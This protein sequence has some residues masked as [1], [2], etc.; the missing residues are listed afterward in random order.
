MISFIQNFLQNLLPKFGKDRLDEDLRITVGT[1]ENSVLPA[2]KNAI[3]TFNIG[4]TSSVLLSL[5]KDFGKYSKVKKSSSLVKTIYEGMEN[6]LDFM[7]GI[8]KVLDTQF[9]ESIVADSLT[10]LKANTIQCLETASFIST[11]SLKFLNFIYVHEAAELN[12]DDSYI[13]DQMSAGDIKYIINNFE[14]FS[15][16]FAII[17][18]NSKTIEKTLSDIPDVVV[19]SDNVQSMSA[20]LGSTKLDPL[21]FSSVVGFTKSPIYRLRMIVAEIQVKRYNQNKELKAILECRQLH[22]DSIKDGTDNPV[23]QKE[24]NV[25]RSRLDRIN[26]EIRSF[27]ESI[28]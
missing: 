18:G 28:K 13:T 7:K 10:G 4:F 12:K 6:S 11:Y 16:G 9:D 19:N 23:V 25:I 8:Q 3:P 17:S 15:K 21:G 27:E 22:L 24:I 20:M 1:I 14:A 5:E 2:Y 26:A